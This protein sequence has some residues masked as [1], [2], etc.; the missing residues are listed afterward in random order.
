MPRISSAAY[1]R[2][3]KPSSAVSSRK[4]RIVETAHLNLPIMPPHSKDAAQEEEKL[5]VSIG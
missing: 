3:R 4:R 5:A 1:S 2:R